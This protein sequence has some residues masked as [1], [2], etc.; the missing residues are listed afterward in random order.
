MNSEAPSELGYLER[1][2]EMF[3]SVPFSHHSTIQ[4]TMLKSAPTAFHS[5]GICIT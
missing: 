5:V 1:L 4:G 3:L 2:P